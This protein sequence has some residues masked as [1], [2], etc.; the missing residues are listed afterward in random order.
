MNNPNWSAEAAEAYFN[1]L[2]FAAEPAIKPQKEP[3]PV[4]DRT[5]YPWNPNQHRYGCGCQ[6]C[7]DFYKSLK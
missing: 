4:E 6:E 7:M 5:D 2:C 3:T 1:S